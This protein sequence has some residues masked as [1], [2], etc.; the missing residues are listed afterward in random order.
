[1]FDSNYPMTLKQFLN[2]I[3]LHENAKILPY[4]CFVVMGNIT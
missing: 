4:V 1:M 2:H 3:V